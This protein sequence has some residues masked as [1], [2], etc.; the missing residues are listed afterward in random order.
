MPASVA[1]IVSLRGLTFDSRGNLYLADV[2][3][4]RA[5]RGRVVRYSTRGRFNVLASG[6]TAPTGLAFDRTDVLYV[7]DG[8]NGTI[9][10]VG[11]DGTSAAFVDDDRLRPHL[12]A[13]LGASGLAFAPGDAALYV[14]N[15][16]DDR[17]FKISIDGDGSAGR[18]SLL[19]DGPS[20]R[21]AGR[22][23]NVLDGKITYEAV[24]EA[25]GLDYTPLAN[26]LP[27]APV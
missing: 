18:M 16:A 19:A 25:H 13:G 8:V 1:G 24:A 11:L 10:W 27:L 15:S 17:L 12:G 26:V 7:T 20:L 21:G 9:L 5:G 14:S 6:L 2:A 3:N 4:G 23:V 22:G